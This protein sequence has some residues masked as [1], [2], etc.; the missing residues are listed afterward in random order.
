MA[1]NWAGTAQIDAAGADLWFALDKHVESAIWFGIGTGSGNDNDL[2]K[3][4]ISGAERVLVRLVGQDLRQ[5]YTQAD[6]ETHPRDDYA[7]FEQALWMWKNGFL[8]NGEAT[9]PK[10][11]AG[12]EQTDVQRDRQDHVIA[13]EARRWLFYGPATVRFSRGE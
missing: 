13:P 7:V 2:R 8:A 11:I 10:W 3:A 6:S 4:A 12:R 5:D 1:F 9:T